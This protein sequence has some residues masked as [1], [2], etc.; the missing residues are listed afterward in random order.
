MIDIIEDIQVKM[1]NKNNK[2]SKNDDS[3][4]SQLQSN[5][6]KKTNNNINRMKPVIKKKKSVAFNRKIIKNDK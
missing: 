3:K 5:I 4:R 1:P 6:N 2:I